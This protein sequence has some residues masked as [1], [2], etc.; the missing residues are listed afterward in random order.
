MR[1]NSQ[2]A[3]LLFLETC[4]IEEDRLC[5]PVASTDTQNSALV[6]KR[7]QAC[8]RN[9]VVMIEVDEVKTREAHH[10]LQ[11]LAVS[12]SSLLHLME[13]IGVL[14]LLVHEDCVE[15]IGVFSYVVNA[16]CEL[17]HCCVELLQMKSTGGAD[18]KN[19]VCKQ[20]LEW[21]LW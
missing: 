4:L 5:R 15:V 16:N 13:Q 21:N 11:Y 14:F 7:I 20:S 3:M 6:A 1:K 17:M 10:R 8:R 12:V 2:H 9:Q 18:S 19:V